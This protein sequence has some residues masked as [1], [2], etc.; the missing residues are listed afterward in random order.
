MPTPSSKPVTLLL[1]KWRSGDQQALDQLMP[2]VYDELRRLAAHYMKSERPSHTLQA[3]AVVNEAYIRL[4]DISVT[5]QDRAHFFA[6]A[7]R[8][9]RRILVD[10]AKASRREKRGGGGVRLTLDEA[11]LS[12]TE[13]APDI[14]ALDDALKNLASMDQRKG[15]II[16]LHFFGGLTYAEMAEALKISEATV[17]RELRL[18]KAW[19][20]HELKKEAP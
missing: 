16:E 4:V 7:A 14:V 19:L 15:Q 5:W 2:L 9:L 6:V 12:S 13:P 1:E 3:T 17:H 10:H 18:A 20:Q 11:L 8:L